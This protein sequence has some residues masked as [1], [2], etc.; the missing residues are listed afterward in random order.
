MQVRGRILRD[1]P[2]SASRATSHIARH[3]QIHHLRHIIREISK[4]LPAKTRNSAKAKELASWGCGTTM[5]VARLVAPRL[6][7]EDHTKD[8]D[9]TPTGIRA[10]AGGLRGHE[11]HGRARPVDG[12]RRSDGRRRDPRRRCAGK[13]NDGLTLTGLRQHGRHAATSRKADT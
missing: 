4:E 9:F 11:A 3:K 7:G 5:H 8:I 12:T 1:G 6:E 10:L 2:Q 13:A